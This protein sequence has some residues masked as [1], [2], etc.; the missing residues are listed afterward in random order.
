MVARVR[1]ELPIEVLPPMTISDDATGIV[2]LEISRACLVAYGRLF[3]V[4]II[5]VT[6]VT[7]CT[8]S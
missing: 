3:E 1:P 5:D 7:P 6:E 2:C 8:R 4:I